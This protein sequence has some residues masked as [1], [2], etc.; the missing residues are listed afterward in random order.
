MCNKDLIDVESQ[1]QHNTI[2]KAATSVIET[3]ESSTNIID[4]SLEDD[5]DD[6]YD[7]QDNDF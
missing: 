4:I 3:Q 5:S 7:I 2:F 6:P 1:M